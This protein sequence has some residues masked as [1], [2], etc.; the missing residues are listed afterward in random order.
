[1]PPPTEE[2]TLEHDVLPYLDPL[3][4][5]EISQPGNVLRVFERGEDRLSIRG[6]GTEVRTDP[7]F[8]S[9]QKTRLL[10][11]TPMVPRHQRSSGR[12]SQQRMHRMPRHLRQ[13]SRPGAFGCS[14][15]STATM[16]KAL[17][18]DKSDPEETSPASPSAMNARRRFRRRSA[19]SVTSIPEPTWCNSYFGTIWWDNESDGSFLS[20]DAE[21]S[22]RK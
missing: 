6:Y 16:G 10:D 20:D 17:H 11:P 19:S 7:V 14:T 4:R 1:M 15:R 18:A 2:E 12:L 22:E 13:R 9:L 3:P 8:L 21:A 5:F